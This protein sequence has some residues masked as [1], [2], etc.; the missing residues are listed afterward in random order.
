VNGETAADV[1]TMTIDQEFLAFG[2]LGCS[3]HLEGLALGSKETNWR[4]VVK[5]GMRRCF[6][7]QNGAG[8]YF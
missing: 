8:R 5:D 7:S 1:K 2:M 3:K 6:F 4:K